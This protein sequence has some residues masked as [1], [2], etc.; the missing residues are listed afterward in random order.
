LTQKGSASRSR[1]RYGTEG[2]FLVRG[3]EIIVRSASVLRDATWLTPDRA[4]AWYRLPAALSL[5]GVFVAAPA[6]RGG[7]AHEGKPLAPRRPCAAAE[8]ALMAAAALLIFPCCVNYVLV[9]LAP[10]PA[11][12]LGRAASG[13]PPPENLSLLAAYLLPLAVRGL[14]TSIGRPLGPSPLPL[15]FAVC[16]RGAGA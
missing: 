14:A 7:P 12:L 16:R 3:R 15:F 1:Q 5:L 2:A 9:V 6:S 4:R 13:F 10:A 8:E 11:P